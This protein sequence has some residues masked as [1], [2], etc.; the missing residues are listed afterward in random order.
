[1][2]V[3][4]MRRGKRKSHVANVS[5]RIDANIGHIPAGAQAKSSGAGGVR[6]IFLRG[7]E[8]FICR[9]IKIYVAV[10]DHKRL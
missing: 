10:M 6:D 3:F 2:G 1:M 4:F 8:K 5:K 7:G 9:A